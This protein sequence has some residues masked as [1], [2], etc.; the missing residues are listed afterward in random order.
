VVADPDGRGDDESLFGAGDV[1]WLRAGDGL[2]DR[3]GAVV[4]GARVEVAVDEEPDD[5]AEPGVVVSGRTQMYRVRTAR[6]STVSAIV[7]FRG[8]PLTRHPRWPGRC[9]GRPAR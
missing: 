2:A 1:L 7:E 5:P 9:P 3:V 4:A 8:R 6:N